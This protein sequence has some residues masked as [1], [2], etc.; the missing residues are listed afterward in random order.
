VLDTGPQDEAWITVRYDPFWQAQYERLAVKKG[1]KKAIVATIARKS[2]P[3]PVE[4]CWWSSGKE[5]ALNE[6]KGPDRVSA[7][8]PG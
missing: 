5:P 3:E 6:V 8:S 7:G 4:G 2:C 1:T